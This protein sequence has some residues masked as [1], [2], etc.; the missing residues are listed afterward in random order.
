MF[1][2]FFGPIRAV[3]DGDLCEQ[4][5]NIEIAKQKLLADELDYTPSEVLKKLEEVR[6]KII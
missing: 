6:N 1:R 4:F 5:S 2:S 3:I